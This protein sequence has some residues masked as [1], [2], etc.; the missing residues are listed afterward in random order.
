M[1]E[2]NTGNDG[3]RLIDKFQIVANSSNCNKAVSIDGELG[4]ASITFKM[5]LS[6]A[7]FAACELPTNTTL[8]DCSKISNTSANYTS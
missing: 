5:E 4:V 1:K 3:S 2:K 8:D 7:E 6:C